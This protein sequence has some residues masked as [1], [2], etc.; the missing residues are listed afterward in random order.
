MEREGIKKYEKQKIKNKKR[1][2]KRD[3]G[4]PGHPPS[5]TSAPLQM[6]AFTT[7][8][9]IITTQAVLVFLQTP[10]Q[11]IAGILNRHEDLWRTQKEW[12]MMSA[13]ASWS[14]QQKP[15]EKEGLL[16]SG[17]PCN[18]KK[19]RLTS[20]APWGQHSPITESWYFSMAFI[21]FTL[22]FLMQRNTCRAQ[23]T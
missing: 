6:Q 5:Q 15:G 8:S 13:Q 10:Q 20:V 16:L 3:R 23:H 11:I 9:G 22:D 2:T 7:R 4:L 1:V 12:E 19:K 18:Q 17:L 21:K 14:V